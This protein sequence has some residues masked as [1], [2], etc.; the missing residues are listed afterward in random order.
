MRHHP[1]VAKAVNAVGIAHPISTIW[2]NEIASPALTNIRI[3]YNDGGARSWPSIRLRKTSSI[4]V[5]DVLDAIY[6]YFQTPLTQQEVS[7]LQG[8]GLPLLRTMQRRVQQ[9]LNIP[10][11]EWRQGYKR[12]D[13]LGENYYFVGLRLMPN[14][15]AGDTVTLDL[16]VADRIS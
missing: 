2:N 5:G 16:V 13:S 6:E 1:T 8:M 9:S 15:N 4:K 3:L 12:I 7:R 14:Q 11:A 10:S